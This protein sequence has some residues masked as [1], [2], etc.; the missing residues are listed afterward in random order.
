MTRRRRNFE[1]ELTMAERDDMISALAALVTAV[2][3]GARAAALAGARDLASR[4][5]DGD[6]AEV[7]AELR[8]ALRFDPV[9]L[10]EIGRLTTD[11]AANLHYLMN[12]PGAPEPVRLA[13]MKVWRQSDVVPYLAQI[14]LRGANGRRP[15]GSA[16]NVGEDGDPQ[17][18][19][20]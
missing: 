8:A 2:R 1:R 9:G 20:P 18:P 12:L 16:A 11:S 13:R 14:G 17:E 19:A 7:E 3:D 15:W 10:A 4:L 6:A 5:G